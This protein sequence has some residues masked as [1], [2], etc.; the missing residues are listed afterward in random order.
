MQVNI[1][2]IEPQSGGVVESSGGPVGVMQV[3][4]DSKSR[5]NIFF[6]DVEQVEKLADACEVLA[7][8]LK[9]ALCDYSQTTTAK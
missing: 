8:Q 4:D 5:L 1:H 9:E 3:A 7:K 2:D 6:Y